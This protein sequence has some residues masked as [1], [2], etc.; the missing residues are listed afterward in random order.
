MQLKNFLPLLLLCG[1]G[2]IA[3]PIVELN[4]S[5]GVIS[6][7]PGDT[8][9]WGFKVKADSTYWVSF[10]SSFI[11]AES[12]PSFGLYSDTIGVLGGPTNFVLA[13]NAPDWTL[14]ASNFGSYAIDPTAA[15]GTSN[16]GTLLVLYQLFDDDPNTCLGCF[17]GTAEQQLAFTVSVPSS[18]Q[19]PEPATTGL[20]LLGAAGIF[21]REVKH[22]ARQR[23]QAPCPHP[24]EE[25]SY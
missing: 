17:V 22:W 10:S 14:G 6:G 5:S 11:L 23:R 13:P 4:P 16:T 25:A 18:S 9:G 2:L 3:A 24:R 21:F 1:A 12:N 20:V 7:Q 15:P 8:V 19:V